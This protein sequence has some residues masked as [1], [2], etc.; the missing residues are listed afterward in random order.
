MKNKKTALYIGI[1]IAVVGAAFLL[2]FPKKAQAG[3]LTNPFPPIN[4]NN[5]QNGS[6]GGNQG[7][8]QSSEIGCGGNYIKQGF[9]LR[10]NSCGTEVSKLQAFLNSSG[11]Y[12][13]VVDGKFGRLTESAVK[14]EQAPFDSFKSMYPNAVRG[15]VTQ[16]YYNAFIA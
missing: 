13:L 14:D 1:G 15:Q 4:P 9:P 12:G 3:G 5:N 16:E 7:A 10:R 8:G 2:F 6:Q 11:G